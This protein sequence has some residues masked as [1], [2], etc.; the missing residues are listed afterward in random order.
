M[1]FIS[2]IITYEYLNAQYNLA[3]INIRYNLICVICP[4]RP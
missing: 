3:M 4:Y 1:I 2:Q